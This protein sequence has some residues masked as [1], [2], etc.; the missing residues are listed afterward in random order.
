[1]A[2]EVNN[3][4]T[5]RRQKSKLVLQ[6]EVEDLRKA[7]AL[8]RDHGNGPIDATP[9]N[10]E[11]IVELET[12]IVS[13]KEEMRERSTTVDTALPQQAE[14]EEI[15]PN[16]G[17]ANEDGH[18]IA[19]I[20]AIEDINEAAIDTTHFRFPTTVV[21]A[22]TQ[23]DFPSPTIS[24]I[25]RSARL[26]FE[27]LFPGENT[28]GLEISDPQPLIE[29]MISRVG[30][31]KEEV[32]QK[33][34]TLAV[35]ETSRLNVVSKFNT[36]LTQLESARQQFQTHKEA[37]EAEKERARSSELEASV[38]EARW[39]QANDKRREIE[40]QR[41]EHRRSIERLQPALEYYQLEV[42]NLTKTVLDLESSHEATLKDLRL[43]FA[44]D[45]DAALA[46]Q[47]IAF[48]EAKSD[49]EAQVAAE[50]IGRR[51]A[52]ESA[53]ERLDRMKELENRQ[54][55]IQSAVHEKQF[56]IRY[57]ESELENTKS[58]HENEVGQLNVRIGKLVSDLSS[59]NAELAATRNEAIR[60]ANLVE[61]EKAAGLKAVEAMQSEMKKCSNNVDVVKDSHAEGVKKRGEEVAQSFGLMTPVVEGGKFRDAEADEKVEGHVQYMRGKKRMS[62]PDSGVEVWG[63][64]AEEA[65]EEGG[66]LMEE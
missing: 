39:E 17:F 47:Q 44:D 57:L 64:I 4:Y 43:E 6:Q 13:L 34:Q 59:V 58:S 18:T 36:A 42:Q 5:G 54:K 46:C 31:L 55:E 11:R 24:E 45:S 23:V 1:M 35:K 51:K 28:I 38:M 3:I 37:W 66:V 53:V 49:L 21:E 61:E 9:E 26:S 48:E 33:Q 30:A 62:R 15:M 12:E 7:L 56:I 63:S 52:E 40:Q 20:T 41:D 60:L 8:A 50:T 27:Y 10:T 29:A 14:D 16:G 19:Q 22:S 65:E 25:C 32:E 2:E